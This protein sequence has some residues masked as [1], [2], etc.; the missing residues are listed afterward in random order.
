M[1]LS[2]RVARTRSPTPG[3]D[4]AGFS[5]GP[6]TCF[7]YTPII[8]EHSVGVVYALLVRSPHQLRVPCP[9]CGP[10]WVTGHRG[11]ER[12]CLCLTITRG[13]PVSPG[14]K[15]QQG[16]TALCPRAPQAPAHLFSH[17]WHAWTPR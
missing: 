2:P 3:P 5:L 16:P 12:M 15:R 1:R 14:P 11:N 13:R 8:P 4:P 17:S 9:Q 10:A 6:Q 7:L